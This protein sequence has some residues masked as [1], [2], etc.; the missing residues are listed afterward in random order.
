MTPDEI[1]EKLE[2]HGILCC[3]LLPIE[4]EAENRE[5]YPIFKN[6]AGIPVDRKVSL[7]RIRNIRIFRN[8]QFIGKPVEGLTVIRDDDQ[9]DGR[10]WYRLVSEDHPQERL[11]EL[12]RRNGILGKLVP[13]K[14]HAPIENG[15]PVITMIGDDLIA[16]END[17][18]EFE[19]GVLLYDGF[20]TMEC[21]ALDSTLLYD[22]TVHSS[23]AWYKVVNGN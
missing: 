5:F 12:A 11:K 7:Q 10:G 19:Q 9:P 15:M 18:C 6:V 14:V 4:V 2:E 20:H 13:V 8:F 22:P 17:P 23:I 3:R 21:H 1:F 16:W